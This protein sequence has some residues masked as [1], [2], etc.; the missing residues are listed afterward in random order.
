MCF[1]VEESILL[2]IEEKGCCKTVGQPSQQELVSIMFY[3]KSTNNRS[4]WDE[5]KTHLTIC[6]AAIGKDSDGNEFIVF[7]TDHMVSI[8]SLGQFE[9]TILKYKIVNSN[10]VTMLSGNPLIFDSIIADCKNCHSYGDVKKAILSNLCTVKDEQIKRQILDTYKIDFAYIQEVLKGNVQNKYIDNVLLSISSHSLETLI[11]LIGFDQHLA[12]IT[13]IGEVGML[14]FRDIDFGCIGSGAVQAMNTLLFQRHSKTDSLTTTLYNVY[15]AK[16]NA[17]VAVGVGEET[18]MGI[19]TEK[20][21]TPVSTEQIKILKDVYEE[22]LVF[23]KKHN[24]LNELVKG[25]TKT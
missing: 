11:L 4:L 7:S 3:T 23:G 16:R 2:L 13:E 25:N 9:K 20:G 18:D 6:I 17:E 12:Q 5:R 21:M 19:L 24:K 1:S 22:E 14:D 10:T 8:G 15:K